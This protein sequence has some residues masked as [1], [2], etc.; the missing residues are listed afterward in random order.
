MG[1]APK[2]LQGEFQMVT[3]M[4]RLSPAR[5]KSGYFGVIAIALIVA[6]GLCWGFAHI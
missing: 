5:R 1:I 3:E 2:R 6:V 4:R